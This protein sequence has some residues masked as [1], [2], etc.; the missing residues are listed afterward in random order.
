MIYTF[1]L[2]CSRWLRLMSEI[3]VNEGGKMLHACLEYL[4]TLFQVQ[5][6]HEK[7]DGKMMMNGSGKDFWLLTTVACVKAL[8]QQ[9]SGETVRS[10]QTSIKVGT[11]QV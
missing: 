4:T 11:L 8:V 10:R 5:V 7:C 9:S 2:H 3:R 6:C 1:D